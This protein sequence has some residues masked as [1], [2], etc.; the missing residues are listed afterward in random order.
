MN[1]KIISQLKLSIQIY[2]C[3]DR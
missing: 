3:F 2:I 1:E